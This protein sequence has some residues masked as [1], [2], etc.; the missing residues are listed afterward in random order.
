MSLR[1]NRIVFN[2]IN[3]QSVTNNLYFIVLN[4][5]LKNTCYVFS[6]LVFNESTK[7]VSLVSIVLSR[8]HSCRGKT[9]VNFTK[10]RCNGRI[11]LS[12]CAPSCREIGKLAGPAAGEAIVRRFREKRGCT[13]SSSLCGYFVRLYA[14]L[15]FRAIKVFAIHT[16]KSFCVL[17]NCVCKL[18]F[19]V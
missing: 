7:L 16:E 12:H 6:S 17:L 1:K 10:N 15:N 9:R 8:T 13:S 19:C 4:V 5:D 18:K 2:L 11:S 14:T 3:K